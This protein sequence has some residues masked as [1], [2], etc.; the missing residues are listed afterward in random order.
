VTGRRVLARGARV[1]DFAALHELL[2]ISG[3]TT[4]L[5]IRTQ[6]WITHYPE[7]GRH[8]LHIAHLLWAAC[9][10]SSPSGCC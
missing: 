6:L 10:C 7:L 9:S 8:G 1:P 5:V 3:V 4:I 2:L